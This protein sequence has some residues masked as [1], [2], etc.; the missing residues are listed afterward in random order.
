MGSYARRLQAV[1]KERTADWIPEDGEL[2]RDSGGS[3]YMG[4]N[5]TPSNALTAIGGGGSSTYGEV[6]PGIPMTY[7]TTRNSAGMTSGEFRTNSAIGPG[8][9]ELFINQL[10][11]ASNDQGVLLAAFSAGGFI[12]TTDVYQQIMVWKVT[13]CVDSGTFYTMTAS[14]VN[15]AEHIA[16]PIW[17]IYVP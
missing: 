2:F 9:T 17:A 15:G 16:G 3:L 10:D 7:S 13:A 1:T 6:I 4:D 8:V 5:V 14:Y 12:Y 11:L